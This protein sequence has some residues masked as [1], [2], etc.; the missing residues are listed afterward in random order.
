MFPAPMMEL[1][2]LKPSEFARVL[3]LS[4]DMK[5][6]KKLKTAELILFI[7]GTVLTL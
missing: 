4:I 2:R 7:P 6:Q 1:L 5:I 3:L